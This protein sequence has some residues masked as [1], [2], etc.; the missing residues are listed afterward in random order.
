VVAQDTGFSKVLPTGEG[1]FAFSTV[2]KA[3]AAVEAINADYPRHAKA[4]RAIAEE[5]FEAGR[6][7]RVLLQAIGLE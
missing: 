7:A 6:V 1:L 2:E 4:A 5:Y 3:A